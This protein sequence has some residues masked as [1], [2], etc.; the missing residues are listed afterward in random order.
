M[1]GSVKRE[2]W[3]DKIKSRGCR[4][5]GNMW[6]EYWLLAWVRNRVG[7][8]FEMFEEFEMFEGFAEFHYTIRKPPCNSGHR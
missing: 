5:T 2:S 4:T 8:R 1:N 7:E 3:A 6:K